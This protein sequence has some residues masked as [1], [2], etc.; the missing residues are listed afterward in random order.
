M[1]K[2]LEGIRVLDF[3]RYIAGPFC[4][5]LLADLGADVIRIERVQGS[6]DRYL[7]PVTPQGDGA[8]FMQ[9]GRNK[10]GMTL[11]PMHPEGREIVRR[12]VATADVVVANLP[13]DTLQAMG[14]DYA[15]LKEVKP[16]I[17]LTLI[18]AFGSGG[19]Y[20]T[21]VGFDGLGQAMSGAMYMSGTPEQPAKSY[22]PFVDYGTASLAAFGTLA[23][24]LERQKS[25]QG[26]V[27]EGALFNT[28]LT[29]TNGTVIEQDALQVNRTATL[30]RSQTSAPADT[31]RT[32]DGWVLVQSVGGP[33]FE[34]WAGLM[35][36]P[37][38]LQDPRFRDDISRGNHGA[39]ISARLARWCAERTTAQVL[40]EME[41]ARVPAGP[42]MSPQDVLDDPHVAAAGLLQR[43][44]YPGLRRPAPVMRPPVTLSRTPAT[45]ERRAPTLGEHTDSILASLGYSD[46]QIAALH[47]ARIV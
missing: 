13:P 11:N 18:S 31:F 15:S 19:P 30:N 9:T 8:L 33:L 45:I 5:T 47:S 32:R 42:V 2:V 34:R 14:L 1:S 46:T 29:L 21:R 3:G 28:A 40:E 36:E 17:I 16:D 44:D 37:H 6:E 7:S 24:L 43:V 39:E 38:W 25:G 35:G 41:A 22:A 10:R 12:L 26:Q 20:S 4:A 27:V 23:A